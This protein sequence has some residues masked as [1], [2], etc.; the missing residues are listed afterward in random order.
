MQMKHFLTDIW[1]FIF[2]RC[3]VLCGKGLLRDEKS[4]C[5]VCLSE[6]PRTKMHAIKDNYV[7]KNFWGKFNIGRATSFFYYS[8]GGSIRK[9]L[10][11]LKYYGNKG[12]GI[13]LGRVMAAEMMSSGFFDDI[14]VIIPV[15]LHPRRQKKR[16]YNQSECLAFGLSSI[17]SIPMDSS[18]LIRIHE[19]ETQTH[20]GLYDRWVN[21]Q[22]LFVCVNPNLYVNKHILIVDDVLTTGATVVS[23]ADSMAEIEGLKI[24]VLTLAVAGET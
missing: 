14:D 9:L 6:L 13:N 1:D 11:E 15:P 7:E 20:K 4:I 10:Y 2:P 12:I 22:G 16:G 17:T 19:N 24:S 23:C 8:K 18:S 21:V 5:T 3:C